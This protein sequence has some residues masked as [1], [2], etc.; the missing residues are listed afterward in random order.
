[1]RLRCQIIGF[2]GY[3]LGSECLNKLSY[4]IWVQREKLN[5]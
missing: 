1:M 4:Q 5:P 3:S 2:Q